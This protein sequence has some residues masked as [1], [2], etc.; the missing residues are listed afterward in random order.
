[1]KEI[2]LSCGK[3]ALVDDDDYERVSQFKWHYNKN[4]Y[5]IRNMR[6][7]TNVYT[8]VYMHR[9]IRGLEKGDKRL[10]DHKNGNGLDNRKSNLRVCTK[11]ENQQNQKPRHTQVS[12]Y[13]GV[14]FY[15]RDQKW[16]ARIVV[17]KK[18]IELGKFDSEVEAALAYN[19]AA[20]K[21][22]G[23]FAWLNKIAGS[24]VL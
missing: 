9:F 17:N 2:I 11:T 16:R 21:Y 14:G 20:I 15:K 1:M 12:K 8:A 23:E 4:G 5:A 3:V 18:D 19:K 10:V 22:H 7:A 24:S 13:K 6:I